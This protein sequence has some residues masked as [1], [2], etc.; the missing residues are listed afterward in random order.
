MGGCNTNGVS[1]N[2]TITDV[3]W[4]HKALMMCVS[5]C[6]FEYIVG[7][8]FKCSIQL[9]QFYVHNSCIYIIIV[10][11]LTIYANTYLEIILY[12]YGPILPIGIKQK[13]QTI[14][15]GVFLA[16]NM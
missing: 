10:F 1:G 7:F 9:F 16:Q 11:L 4:E 5:E 8:C 12:L 14:S 15:D 2:I 3:N 6:V 13:I